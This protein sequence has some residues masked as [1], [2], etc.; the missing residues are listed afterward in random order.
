MKKLT[1]SLMLALFVLSI[2]PS[3]LQAGT[4]KDKSALTVAVPDTPVDSDALIT[5]LEQIQSMDISSLSALEKRQLRR[6][7]RSIEAILNGGYIV[8]GGGTLLL[9]IILLI[10]LL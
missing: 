4:E 10:L 1:L 9:V 3:D 7:V 8:L 6:E 2:M 5:R